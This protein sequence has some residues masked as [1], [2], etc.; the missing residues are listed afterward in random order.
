MWEGEFLCGYSSPLVYL[1]TL[2]NS[3]LSWTLKCI[4]SAEVWWDPFFSMVMGFSE[5]F[6]FP[7]KL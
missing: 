1:P 6:I 7:D 5:H 3:P 4:V 2:N